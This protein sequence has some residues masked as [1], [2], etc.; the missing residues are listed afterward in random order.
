M[1]RNNTFLVNVVQANGERLVFDDVVA[2]RIV[3]EFYNLLVMKD[4]MPIIGEVTGSVTVIGRSSNYEMEKGI[5]YFINH[6]NNFTLIMKG[7]TGKN[8]A[9]LMGNVA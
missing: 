4:Y 2:V 1:Q 8:V 5:A 9:S 6:N 3:S 7:N